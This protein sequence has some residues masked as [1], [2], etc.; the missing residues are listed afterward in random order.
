MAHKKKRVKVTQKLSP[1][2]KKIMEE[3]NRIIKE[4]K[5]QI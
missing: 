3:N 4:T 1:K 2:F 5:S